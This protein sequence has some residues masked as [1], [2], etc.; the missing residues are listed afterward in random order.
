VPIVAKVRR[1]IEVAQTAGGGVEHVTPA[2]ASPRQAPF[3]HPFMHEVS[4]GA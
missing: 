2:H 1:V 4:C 3:R